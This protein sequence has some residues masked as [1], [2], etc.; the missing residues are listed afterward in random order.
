MTS[1]STHNQPNDL[2]TKTARG[3]KWGF[4]NNGSIQLLSAL[5]G[6]VLARRLSQEDYG[7]VGMLA[8]FSSL[9]ST[10]QDS[11]FCTA[12]TNRPQVIHREYNS[13][14]WFNV[15][16][17]VLLVSLLWLCAPLLVSFFDEPRLLWLSRFY[18]VGL[19]F[20]SLGAVPRALLFR[21]MRQ[22]ELTIISI[23]AMLV[24]GTV[25]IV[26]AYWGMA[27]WG[28][29]AQSVV[30]V[31]V[32]IVMSWKMSGWKPSRDISF[33]PFR[34]MIG[35]TSKILVTNVFT[36][37]NN[38]VFSLLLGKFYRATEVGTFNQA[39]KWN[40]MGTNTISGMV[41]GVAQP[42]FVKVGN[43]RER[44]C[45]AFSKML[46]FTCFVCFPLMLGLALI[47]PEFIVVLITDK[48]L[49]SAALMRWLCI[50][51]AFLPLSMLSTGLLLSRGKSN[52]Y[53]WNVIAQGITILLT[54]LAVRWLGGSIT[55]MVVAYAAIVAFWSAIWM[56]FIHL[57]IGLRLWQ[58]VRDV[59]P[60]LVV[61]LAAMAATYFITRSITTPWLL[62]ALRIPLAAMIYV[63]AL[64]LAGAKILRESLSYLK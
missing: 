47:A 35:F 20:S 1:E 48:W 46:R 34:R 29:A 33:E 13:V 28:I 60:F 16:M 30:Y 52:V 18:F 38:N 6:I 5:I 42:T 64:W 58:A 12:L 61:A 62:L 15:G 41:Q 7:L 44:L 37:I 25:G 43:D 50:G 23:T 10:L 9:A 39:N 11:G 21:D 4:L 51:G 8:I 56:Y 45:R 54:V 63:A 57:E 26:M 40:T 24:S 14:F 49:P 59:V 27:Y 53:M 22:K 17:S 2:K 31:F 36:Q 19:L 55:Q 3:I 32:T